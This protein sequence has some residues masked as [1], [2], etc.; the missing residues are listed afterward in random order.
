MGIFA[1]AKSR[2]IIVSSLFAVPIKKFCI[3]TRSNK[4]RRAAYLVVADNGKPQRDP[5]GGE[6]AEGRGR[7]AS[8]Q[9][10]ADRR[11]EN[12]ASCLP[13]CAKGKTQALVIDLLRAV[14]PTTIPIEYFGLS[15]N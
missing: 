14:A 10:G 5:I 13:F 9:E 8:D 15:I 4:R 12:P 6:T 3:C 7:I 11:G 1:I 2:K